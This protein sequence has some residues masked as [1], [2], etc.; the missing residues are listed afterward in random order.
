MKKQHQPRANWELNIKLN[1]QAYHAVETFEI[2][3]DSPRGGGNGRPLVAP[4]ASAWPSMQQ[5]NGASM[6]AV[7]LGPN[8]K[9]GCAGTGVFLP[10]RAGSHSET[11]K[12]SGRGHSPFRMY[13]LT[14]RV[15]FSDL[16]HDGFSY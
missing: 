13:E 7:F 10:R 9:R 15:L 11:R 8:G 3:P 4:A 6:R 2:K 1:S 16:L 14:R 12:K 5:Q